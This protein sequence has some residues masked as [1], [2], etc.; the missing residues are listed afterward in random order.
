MHQPDYSDPQTGE[1]V[2]PWVRLH[3]SKDYLRMAEIVRQY[4]KVRATFNLVPSLLDQIQAYAAG[5]ATDQALAVSAKTD[6]TRQEKEFLLSF[7]LSGGQQRILGR[8]GR[9]MELKARRDATRSD[10]D[11]FCQADYLDIVALF[12]LAWTDTGAFEAD[13]ELQSLTCKGAGYSAEDVRL[14]LARQ[15]EA[16]ETI[17]PRYRALSE[18]EQVELTTSPYHHPILPLLLSTDLA[19]RPSPHLPLPAP[20]FSAPED[21]RAHLARAVDTHAAHF[22]QKPAGLWPPEGA[23]SAEVASLAAEMGFRWIASDEAVLARS[24]RVR[25]DRDGAGHVRNPAMLYQPYR[26]AQGTL[27]LAAIFRDHVLSDRV[28]FV[29]QGMDARAAADDFMQRL[30]AV[31]ERVDS[32]TLPYLVTVILDGENAWEYYEQ[33]GNP[34]L[35]SLYQRLSEDP[36]VETVTVSQYLE[37]HPPR[38]RIERLSTGS[39]INGNLETWI[40]EP[41]HNRAWNQLRQTREHLVKWE[42][43]R[44]EAPRE[45]VQRAWEEIYRAEGSDWFWWYSSKN[46]AQ[47]EGLFDALYRARLRNV[48]RLIGDAPPEDLYCGEA[49]KDTSGLAIPLLAQP[50]VEWFSAALWEQA[51]TV[52]PAAA[53]LGAAQRA[54]MPIRHLRACC[55][56]ERLHLRLETYEPLNGQS[57]I[58]EI[59]PDGDTARPPLSILL[60]DGGMLTEG[61][62]VLARRDTDWAALAIPLAVLSTNRPGEIAMRVGLTQPSGERCWVPSETPGRFRLT[63][64]D[65]NAP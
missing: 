12:N 1:C 59:W 51:L 22:G 28:G 18:Q 57:L 44:P 15:R 48:Y 5:T 39:W 10:P 34:F 2:V 7:F 29:Y 20:A 36:L 33:N 40:G 4:P 54:S 42:Q 3:A 49:E 26:V 62:G 45:V 35:H 16:V 13:R 9:Y 14:I 52:T 23:V 30:H 32:D 31:R 6:W 65:V 41:A 19:A 56:Q 8:S 60:L 27:P 64:P 38:A 25:V 47:E 53:S 17:I 21:A 43:E 55:D 37:R 58:V 24:L 46:S 63:G 11:A 50:A 61:N